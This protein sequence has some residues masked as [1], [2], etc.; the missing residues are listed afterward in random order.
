MRR[1]LFITILLCLSGSIK[2]LDIDSARLTRGN[3]QVQIKADGSWGAPALAYERD[4]VGPLL[5]RLGVWI[6]GRDMSGQLI[7]GVFDV[8]S[9]EIEFWPGPG[10]LLGGAP[11]DPA[12]FNRVYVLHS[13]EIDQHRRSWKDAGY[14]VPDAIKQW[15]ANGPK[16]F[17]P[18]LA[19]YVDYNVNGT[20]DPEFGDYPFVPSGSIM[21]TISNDLLG[22]HA[23][24]GGKKSGI[25]C[26]QLVWVPVQSGDTL[27][28]QVVFIRLTLHNRSLQ[29]Y[30]GVNVA[31]AG[32][33]SI[34]DPS[35]DYL[36][37]QVS[38]HAICVYNGMKNDAVFGNDPPALALYFLNRPLASSMYFENSADAVKGRPSEMSHF[39]HLARGR[40]KTGKPLA[41]GRAGLDGSIETSFVY[42]NGSD[43]SNP[44]VWNEFEAGNFPGKRYAVF[45]CDSFNLDAGNSVVIEAALGILPNAGDDA[46]QIAAAIEAQK[47]AISK[48]LKRQPAQPQTASVRFVQR[49]NELQVISLATDGLNLVF[50]DMTG[51]ELMHC[52]VVSQQS[53]NLNNI[54]GPGPYLVSA[55]SP[56]VGLVRERIIKNPE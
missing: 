25:E 35:D 54:P 11:G 10:G 7:G 20:Y 21:Y 30:T 1:L 38:S 9:G 36:L 14:R 41:F 16:G 27:A 56:Q 40:W 46:S 42:S 3:I 50:Y 32:G 22:N 48:Q 13:N 19:P 34:G 49:G 5:E 28:D 45:S 26:Q 12:E 18:V 44:G 2:G 53:I 51:R 47:K 6:T 33:F 4:V 23:L 15:P 17:D 24:S 8:F 29:N 31:L 39:H 52:K 55:G 37:T 43:P